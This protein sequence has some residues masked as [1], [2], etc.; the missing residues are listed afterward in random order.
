M[1][2][3]LFLA[4]ILAMVSVPSYAGITIGAFGGYNLLLNDVSGSGITK[5]GLAFGGNVGYKISLLTIGI[6]SG[7]FPMYK[8]SID[9]PAIPTVLP[10]HTENYYISAIPVLGYAKLKPPVIPVYGIAGAGVYFVKTKIENIGA[11]KE[12]TESSSSKGKFGFALGAG[13]QFGL[14]PIIKVNIGGLYHMIS[15]D[16]ESTKMFTIL[17]AVNLEF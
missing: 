5:G 8:S 16:N 3:L 14:P 11:N 15:T 4:L 6:L 7:Y 1:R 17:A 10:A 12:T 2:R 13:Y 9:Y